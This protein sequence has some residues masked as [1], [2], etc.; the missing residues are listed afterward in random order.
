M[1]KVYKKTPKNILVLCNRIGYYPNIDAQIDFEPQ[2]RTYDMLICVD[3]CL[4]LSIENYEKIAESEIWFEYGNKFTK[5]I[6][7]N[8][9]DHYSECTIN[10]G[11]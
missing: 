7:E 5:K 11:L 6:F 8:A 2:N 10:K 3:S 4:R 9:M 1:E